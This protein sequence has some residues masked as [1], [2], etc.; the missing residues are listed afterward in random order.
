MAIP[1]AYN[2]RNI[3][4]RWQ[5]TLL[6]IAGIALVVTVFVIMI[7]L[8]SGLRIALAA[9]GSPDNAI[10]VQRGAN[11]ELTSG[12]A[13]ANADVIAA[14]SRVARTRDGKP[15]VSPE[16]VV[17]ATLP[18]R[19]DGLQANVQLRGVSP[20]AFDVRANVR[21]TE[22]RRMEPGTTEV[23]VGRRVIERFSGADVGSTI[24][25]KQRDWLV[26]GVFDA[27]D[28]SFESELWGALDVMAS[29]F[30]RQGGYQSLTVKMADPGQ[31]TGW[32]SEVKANPRLPVDIKSEPAFYEEQAGPVAGALLGL[33]IFVSFVMAIG[34]VFGAMNTMYAVVSLRTRE[35]GTLRALG[36]ARRSILVS[37]V[38]ES[39]F[40][41]LV[42]GALGVLLALPANGLTTA[43]GN[44]TF[45]ELAFAFRITPRAILGGMVF[46]G[47]M[48]V[49]GGL[50]PAVRAARLPILSALREA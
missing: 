41:A 16:I 31:L 27:D 19:A 45:S 12:V 30:N 15:A 11:A 49:I 13:R 5:V 9:T 48:G 25:I 3:R 24:R 40:I 7:A 14:D 21:V 22:G 32:A 34:A 26:V 6:A 33:T 29:V 46:A 23:I 47:F 20:A 10:V 39:T 28:S 4:Q 36:F 37:F 42:A 17:V 2:L 35:I 44:V 38:L 18:K 43:T 50:L 1:L 8:T